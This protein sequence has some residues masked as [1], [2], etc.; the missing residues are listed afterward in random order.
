MKPQTLFATLAEIAAEHDRGDGDNL[1]VIPVLTDELESRRN[2]L[3][4]VA[5]SLGGV[6]LDVTTGAYD[7]EIAAYDDAVLR[8]TVER[9]LSFDRPGGGRSEIHMTYSTDRMDAHLRTRG[10]LVTVPSPAET[11][12]M[13]IARAM[14]DAD[15]ADHELAVVL[16]DE[17]TFDEASQ[18]AVLK[19]LTGLGRQTGL[20]LGAARTLVPF[21]RSSG[22]DRKRHCQLHRGVRYSLTGDAIVRRNR[23]RH[24]LD[25]VRKLTAARDEPL[26]LFLGAGFSE[27][28][29]MPV[30]NSVRNSTIRRLCQLPDVH[31]G[32]TDEDLAAALYRFADAAGVNLLAVR[33][34][35]IGEAEFAFT[36]TLEQAARIESD[37]L[38]VPDPPTITDLRERHNARIGDPHVRFGD[39]VYALHRI[40]QAGR[41]VVVVTLNFDE[42]A[43]HDHCNALEIAIDDDDFR[44]LAPTLAE[45][46]QG[47][48]HPDGKIP[49][50]KLHGT[51]NR[52]ETC[53]VT[54]AQTRSGITPAKVEALMALVRDLP[55]N[56][57]V[58]WVYVGASMR[59]IDLDG[60]LGLREFNE[61]VS[62]R[63]VAPWPEYSVR[64]FVYTKNRWWAGRGETL[65]DRT[66]TETADSFMNTLAH[67]WV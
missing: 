59:D 47:A 57:R 35:D 30:G 66:V 7:R 21:I 42:L 48:A 49:L 33:E 22:I 10:R 65:L 9:D 5:E 50:L 55:E 63:W 52:P 61:G 16:Y 8:G 26:V 4:E 24:L 18:Q 29:R 17:N 40:I 56:H 2:L 1:L 15:L 13:A 32:R 43:E 19:M 27:S 20:R 53:I 54:D 51:I 3:A 60:I 38:E 12:L 64:R 39:A 34:R 44:R 58:P 23:T 28:S 37:L 45:M 25:T 62:E 46:R 67:E 31:D 36:A 11:Q 14:F 6:L 41:R